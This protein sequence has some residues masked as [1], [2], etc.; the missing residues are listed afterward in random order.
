MDDTDPRVQYSGDWALDIGTFDT[1]GVFGP[2]YNHSMHGTSQNSASFSFTFEGEYVQVRGAKDT[3]RIPEA[4]NSNVTVL[5][6]WTCEV[7]GSAIRKVNYRGARYDLT[8]NVLCEQGR[9]SRQPHT[10]TV[11]VTIDDPNTQM[12]WLDK[13]E[14]VPTPEA[15]LANEV[16]KID[17]SDP[18]IR[19]DNNSGNWKPIGILFNGTGTTGAS[20]SLDFNGTSVSLYGFNEG[21]EKHWQGSSGRYYVDNSGDTTFEIPESRTVPGSSNLTDYYHELL[22]TTPEMSPGSHEMV[23]TFTGVKTGEDP[24]QWLSIDYLYV[25]AS[26]GGAQ[27]NTTASTAGSL[28]TR[29][30]DSNSGGSSS[31]STPVGPIVGGVIGGIAGLALLGLAIFFFLKRRKDNNTRAGGYYDSVPFNPN[32]MYAAPGATAVSH[33]PPTVGAGYE[34]Y[35]DNSTYTG[36]ASG[37]NHRTTPSVGQTLSSP[38]MQTTTFD[39]YSDE[40]AHGS[41]H[42]GSNSNSGGGESGPQPASFAVANPGPSTLSPNRSQHWTDLQREAVAE[43]PVVER[44]H[45]DSGIRYPQQQ[46]QVVDVPPTYTEH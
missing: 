14:Y 37:A 16:I 5:A 32:N 2:P 15:N 22:F 35:S 41:S 13:I 31:S 28:P 46:Q 21:S 12:F 33:P 24:L 39:P 42:G 34:P 20:M 38:S 10:L 27:L 6:S 19:Y 4:S 18:S 43:Q 40:H 1:L 7:D 8:H 11:N 17:G 29:G 36:S 3:R 44:R 30:S 9:L 45:Q 23:I 25:T 26:E